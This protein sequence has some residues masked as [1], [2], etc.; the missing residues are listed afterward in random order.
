M[1]H[2]REH[3]GDDYHA[4]AHETEVMPVDDEQH[5]PAPDSHGEHAEGEDE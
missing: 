2:L 5:M 1:G 3:Q 4:G